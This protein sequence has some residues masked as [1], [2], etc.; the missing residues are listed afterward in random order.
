MPASSATWSR[1]RSTSTNGARS[2]T[3][4]A[5]GAS[6][7]VCRNAM[8]PLASFPSSFVSGLNGVGT[9]DRGSGP[10]Y[11]KSFAPVDWASNSY[12]FPPASP[13]RTRVKRS[14]TGSTTE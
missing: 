11:A 12:R 4:R 2:A 5:S 8:S 7:T 3:K 13:R 9:Y 10:R 6:L 1:T 14:S